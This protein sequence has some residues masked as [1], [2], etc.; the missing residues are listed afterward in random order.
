VRI[1]S[2]RSTYMDR[3]YEMLDEFTA[4]LELGA[5]PPVDFF[6]FL[7]W[8]PE[9]FLGN[10][11]TRANRVKSIMESLHESMLA[12]VIARREKT[13]SKDTFV[14]GLL[15]DNGKLGLSRHQLSFLG[16][17]LVEGGSETP[18]ALVITFIQAMTRWPEI[19]KRGQQELD[20]VIGEGRTPTW[21]DYN[22][23]PYVAAIVKECVRWR[24]VAPLGMPHLLDQGNPPL[25]LLYV[26]YANT[27]R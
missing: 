7:K 4:L 5:T 25:Y 19:Q 22:R 24:P 20:A 1:P 3:L 12:H 21:A 18:A 6:P 26:R 9:R 27:S 8:I 14:D 16:G 10:W 2:I 13:G 17:G 23:L 15:N 11:I